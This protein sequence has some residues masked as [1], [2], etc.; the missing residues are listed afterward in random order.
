MNW[1]QIWDNKGKIFEGLKNSVFKKEAVEEI[2]AERIKICEA[3]PHIDKEGTKCMIPGT[4]PCCGLCG[5][6]LGLKTRSLSSA[7]DDKRWDAI[8]T[9]E[10]EDELN[11]ATGDFPQTTEA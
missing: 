4:Q 9:Q 11:G 5:C 10:Q 2:A 7:C 1:K 8:L 3:C 6:K